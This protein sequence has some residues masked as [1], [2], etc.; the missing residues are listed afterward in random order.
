MSRADLLRVGGGLGSGLVAWRL[1]Q[2]RPELRMRRLERDAHLGGNHTWSSRM[3]AVRV[4]RGPQPVVREARVRLQR[5]AADRI[6]E[7]P[8]GGCERAVHRVVRDDEGPGAESA[9]MRDH[10]QRGER[11]RSAERVPAP[12]RGR[13]LRQHGPRGEDRRREREADAGVAAR[14]RQGAGGRSGVRVRRGPHAPDTA[15]AGPSRRP[16]PVRAVRPR[17]LPSS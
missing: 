6:G 10:R 15:P 9:Q 3:A 14:V 8:A 13:R 12:V 16:Q 11:R 1:A 5:D 2:R 17:R 4:V 7:P